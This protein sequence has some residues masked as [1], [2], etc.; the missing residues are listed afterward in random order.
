MKFTSINTPEEFINF[1]KYLSTRT[2]IHGFKS[3]SSDLSVFV[4]LDKAKIKGHVNVQR[5]YNHI[6]ALL[7]E[8]FPGSINSVQNVF[9]VATPQVNLTDSKAKEKPKGASD[10]SDLDLFG[11]DSEDEESKEAL[12]AIIKKKSDK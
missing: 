11:S 8:N 7:S 6:A 4:T 5:W 1:D 9:S 3:T 2:Y 12:K 10:D